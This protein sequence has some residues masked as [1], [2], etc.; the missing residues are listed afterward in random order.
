VA[1]RFYRQKLSQKLND[2]GS[3]Y[4]NVVIILDKMKPY[5]SVARFALL[6]GRKT[7]RTKYWPCDNVGIGEALDLERGTPSEN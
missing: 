5:K 3:W 1:G 4:Q 2:L 7:A 6:I